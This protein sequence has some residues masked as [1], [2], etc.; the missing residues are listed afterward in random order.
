MVI[1]QALKVAFL[2]NYQAHS[3]KIQ[4]VPDAADKAKEDGLPEHW[5]GRDN[6][7][8]VGYVG[9]LFPGKGMEIIS[10]LCDGFADMDFHVIGGTEKDIAYWKA[11]TSQNL[12]FHGFISQ[13]DLSR[14]INVLDICL[15]PNQK[16][17]LTFGDMSKKSCNISDYTSPLK[18]FEYMAHGKAIVASDLQVLREVLNEDNAIL[19]KHDNIEAWGSALT[20]LRE[21]NRRNNLGSRAYEDFIQNYTWTQRAAKALEGV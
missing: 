16:N 17:V 5:P 18:M 21:K 8:Q 12:F 20:S 14:Y 11:K 13:A 1:T 15:L 9:N 2:K 3:N 7:L 10:Q 19:V 4:V 6:C